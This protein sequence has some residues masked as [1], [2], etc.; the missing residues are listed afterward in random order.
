MCGNVIKV[1]AVPSWSEGRGGE[2]LGFTAMDVADFW[3]FL[4]RSG[5][6]TTHPRRRAE[7]LEHRH[8]RVA[9]DHIVDFQIHVDTARR[10]IDTWDMLG[11]ANQV[12]DGTCSG[13]SFWYLQPWLIGQGRPFGPGGPPHAV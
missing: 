2:E 12:M 4:E 1:G 6:A 3:R 9:L 11:A 5:D 13:D 10:P 7:W 8:S